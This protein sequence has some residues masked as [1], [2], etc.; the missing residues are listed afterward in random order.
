M[1]G[2]GVGRPYVL[3]RVVRRGTSITAR[4]APESPSAVPTMSATERNRKACGQLTSTGPPAARN[5][6]SPTTPAAP[7]SGDG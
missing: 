2:Q 4:S 6:F 7:G 3:V 1:P 5:S